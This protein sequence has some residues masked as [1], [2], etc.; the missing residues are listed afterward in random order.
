[1]RLSTLLLAL[2]IASAAAAAPLYEWRLDGEHVAD[3]RSV[4]AVSGS[5]SGVVNGETRVATAG[6]GAL[7][8]DGVQNI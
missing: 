4:T 8:F 2:G 5:V 1:M 3:D 6:F 7:V